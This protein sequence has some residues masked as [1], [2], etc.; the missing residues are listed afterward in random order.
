MINETWIINKKRKISLEYKKLLSKRKIL[1]CELKNPKKH[2]KMYCIFH[3]EK[4]I[5]DIYEC[6]GISCYIKYNHM[7]YIN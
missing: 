7:P 4:Y 3:D 6:C 5:C 2:K 1:F